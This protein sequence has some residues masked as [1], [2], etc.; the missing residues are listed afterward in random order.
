MASSFY[1][2]ISQST[3]L[4]LPFILQCLFGYRFPGLLGYSYFHLSRTNSRRNFLYPY[5]DL[6]WHFGPLLTPDLH[7]HRPSPCL[8]HLPLMIGAF[9]LL[10]QSRSVHVLQASQGA[11]SRADNSKQTALTFR[12]I[13]VNSPEH[14]WPPISDEM[15]FSSR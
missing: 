9:P 1:S 12:S 10:T 14:P 15:L 11:F 3:D 5:P 2:A 13:H 6:T 7:R 4:I 8:P